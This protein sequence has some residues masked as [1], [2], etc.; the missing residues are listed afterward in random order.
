MKLKKLKLSEAFPPRMPNFNKK[1]KTRNKST[2]AVCISRTEC[3][4]GFKVEIKQSLQRP[5]M[6]AGTTL[7]MKLHAKK[8]LQANPRQLLG[9][10]RGREVEIIHWD[11]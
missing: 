11:R 6:N 4:C 8:C 10:Y 2:N 5:Q 9:E 1:D 7:R 3:P